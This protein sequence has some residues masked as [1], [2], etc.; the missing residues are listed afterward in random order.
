MQEYAKNEQKWC[1]RLQKMSNKLSDDG[2][3]NIGASRCKN[4]VGER[5]FQMIVNFPRRL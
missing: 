5:I 3:K 1:C 4:R 2:A